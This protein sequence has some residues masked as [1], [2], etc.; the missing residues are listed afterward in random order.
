[1]INLSNLKQD[2]AETPRISDEVID[3]FNRYRFYF[4]KNCSVNQMLKSQA[5][6]RK[7]LPLEFSPELYYNID[8]KMLKHYGS[9]FAYD[10]YIKFLFFLVTSIDQKGI[11]SP[12]NS[13]ELRWFHPGGKRVTLAKYLGIDFLPVIVQ[14][15]YDLRLKPIKTFKELDDLYGN[16]CS[17]KYRK[18][19]DTLEVAWHGETGMRDT[20]GYD[21]WYSKAEE[22]RNKFKDKIDIPSYLLEEGLTVVNPWVNNTITKGIFK[23]HFVTKSDSPLRI[24]INDKKLLEADLWE[25]F[26]HLDPSV[27]K[28]IDKTESIVIYNNFAKDDKIVLKNKN[29]RLIKTLNRT[30]F[31]DDKNIHEMGLG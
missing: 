1:M 21:N 29:C 10:E 8:Y 18:D 15:S 4:I 17:Y 19:T 22:I 13:V 12:I 25:L 6:D 23:T 9:L 30:K 31:F 7:K 14:S 3:C 16:N 28:K 2:L 5:W 26:F 27:Y 20:N 24:E 11:I